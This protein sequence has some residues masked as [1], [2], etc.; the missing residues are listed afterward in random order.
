[1]K[2]TFRP[3][4]P[5][6]VRKTPRIKTGSGKV[7]RAHMSTSGGRKGDAIGKKIGKSA[8]KFVGSMVADPYEG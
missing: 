4:K 3:T 8:G 6:A 1:M 7:K 5:P 2:K